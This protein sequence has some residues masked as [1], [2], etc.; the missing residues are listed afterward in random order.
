MTQAALESERCTVE[1]KCSSAGRACRVDDRTCQ[2]DAVARGL[3]V[4]CERADPA[5]YVYCPPGGAQRDSGIVW[6]LLAVAIGIAAVGGIL[7]Y[8]ILRK[9]I[10]R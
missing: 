8:L 7:S 5:G 10:T 4:T 6:V 2:S 1:R 3:E 9:R